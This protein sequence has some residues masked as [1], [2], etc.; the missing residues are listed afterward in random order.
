MATVSEVLDAAQVI[1]FDFDGPVCSVFSGYPAPEVARDLVSHL[2]HA[3][4][5]VPP[6]VVEEPDPLEVL[7]WSASLGRLDLTRSADDALRAA[8]TKAV[9]TAAPTAHAHDCI[10]HFHEAGRRMV[11]VSN[12]SAECVR[13]YLD[14]HGLTTMFEGVT[15]R[16]P[17]APHL[18]KP[19]PAP[20]L[21]AVSS[22]GVP[23]GEGVLIGDS[24]TDI[25]GARAAGVHIIAYANKPR[26]VDPFMGAA[27]DALILSMAELLRV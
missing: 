25:A 3:G 7:R 18:M 8:E 26:K 21:K 17:A 19:N 22:V 14:L 6:R 5:D 4:I 2:Q 1:M 13:R 10:R 20:I 24:L 11:V 23:P 12:N 15:G 9:E 27:P 16:F